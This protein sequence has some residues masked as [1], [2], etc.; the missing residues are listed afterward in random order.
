MNLT[1]SMQYVSY[2]KDARGE[3]GLPS[4]LQGEI[5]INA[6]II[7]SF[8]NEGW[9]TPAS[10]PRTQHLGSLRSFKFF[11]H[12]AE[13]GMR[14]GGALQGKRQQTS[15]ISSKEQRGCSNSAAGIAQRQR[16][17][18]ARLIWPRSFY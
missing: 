5:R 17:Q 10:C 11:S 7:F 2:N 3:A 8:A 16:L 6:L 14:Q 15:Q 18:S 9:L 1:S 4:K 12:S 13:P